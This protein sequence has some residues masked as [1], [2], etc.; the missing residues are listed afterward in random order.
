MAFAAC[1]PRVAA[2]VLVAA[3]GPLALNILIPSLPSLSAAFDVAYASVQL[4]L[5]LFLVGLALSQ[6]VYGPLSDHF[7]R[8]PILLGGLALYVAGSIIGLLASSLAMLILGRLVQAVGGCA[9]L[10]L[11]RAIIRDIHDRDK[12]ASVLAYVTMAMVGAPMLAPLIGGLLDAWL[13]W[14]AGFGV[15]AL[16][17]LLALWSA[18]RWLP[19]THLHRQGLAGASDVVAGYV[20]LFARPAFG[21]YA[22]HVAFASAGFFAFLS[23]APY[24]MARLLEYSADECGPYFAL[25]FLGYLVGYLVAGRFSMAWGIDRMILAGTTITAVGAAVLTGL[26]GS[27]ILAPLALFGSM[28]VFTLGNGLSLP[29]AIAGA[30]SVDSRRAGAASGMV[31]FLQMGI[32]ALASAVA[33]EV[34]GDSALPLALVILGFAAAAMLVVMPVVWSR[35]SAS[36]PSADAAA[37]MARRAAEAE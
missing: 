34:V 37:A 20:R 7:G 13:G 4:A 32:G 27:G 23:G 6:L 25:G 30:L 29:N 2:L 22:G 8:R 21:R 17:G 12:A 5:S 15:C 3:P 16:V 33:G 18:L 24:I 31:G 28:L 36:G 19:E 9:G 1:K 11:S 35:R 26:I 14:R 10:V